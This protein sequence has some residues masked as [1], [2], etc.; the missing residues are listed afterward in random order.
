MKSE[1]D[2]FERWLE[3]TLTGLA[4]A[5]RT[6]LLKK[7]GMSMRRSNQKRQMQQIG[8][9]GRKWAARKSGSKRKMMK[10]LRLARFLKISSSPNEVSVGWRGRTAGMARVH[11][12]GLRD[13]VSKG[14]VRVKYEAREL[15]G[16][17][18]NDAD[19][20]SKIIETWLE[21]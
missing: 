12:F 16:Q 18:R 4:P 5:S 13:R 21:S 19:D 15:L 8:L 10:K 6:K 20:L 11:H 17:G 7:L 14:G 2:D 3:D 9:D 1:F